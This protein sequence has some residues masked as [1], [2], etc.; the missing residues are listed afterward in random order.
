MRLYICFLILTLALQIFSKDYI[1]MSTG[2][3]NL[4]INFRLSEDTGILKCTDYVLGPNRQTINNIKI[5][6]KHRMLNNGQPRTILKVSF[7]KESSFRHK[8][9]VN[10]NNVKALAEMLTAESVKLYTIFVEDVSAKDSY[11]MN[12]FAIKGSNKSF[13]LRNNKG[14]IYVED[15]L[16]EVVR[17]NFLTLGDALLV[18]FAKLFPSKVPN[19]NLENLMK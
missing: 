16:E 14:I 9:V 15:N 18:F 8:L 12:I 2:I 1:L 17:Q 13:N 3:L 7:N 19:V 5:F 4:T 10:E 6:M 11:I